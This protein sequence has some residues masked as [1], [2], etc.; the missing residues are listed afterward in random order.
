MKPLTPDETILGLLAIQARHGY[1]LLECFRHSSQLGRVWNLSNS[2]IYAVLKRLEQNGFITGQQ[3]IS[4]NAPPRIEYVL[5]KAGE[6][7][8]EQWL[9][10][11]HP[12]PS[13]RHIR[14]EFL[15]RLYIAQQLG[16]SVNPIIERQQATCAEHYAHLRQE[17]QHAE[18]G[19]NQMALELHIAQVEA[20]LTWI[21]QLTLTQLT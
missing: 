6:A 19:I 14:V 7:Q 20:V 9:H 21:R 1:E 12:S 11:E 5:T 18:P 8:L 16:I 13:I 15:S 3:V 17:H 10:I 4:E 2:Q